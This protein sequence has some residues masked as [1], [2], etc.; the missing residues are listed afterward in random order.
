M[1]IVEIQHCSPHRGSPWATGTVT[2]SSLIFVSSAMTKVYVR[3]SRKRYIGASK[4]ANSCP[5]RCVFFVVVSALAAG[6][7]QAAWH[8]YS[9]FV[10]KAVGSRRLHVLQ[11]KSAIWSS[12]R[13]MVAAKVE[14]ITEADGQGSDARISTDCPYSLPMVLVIQR[15][16]DNTKKVGVRD[17][18]SASRVAKGIRHPADPDH[19]KRWTGLAVT[20]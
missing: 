10:C 1:G 11:R 17:I 12:I 7:V 9:S 8:N 13:V 14:A 3:W 5:F 16:V 20:S 18:V 19:R 15:S 2:V 6:A 4:M